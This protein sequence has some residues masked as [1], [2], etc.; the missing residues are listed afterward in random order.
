MASPPTISTEAVTTSI[1]TEAFTETLQKGLEAAAK[2]REEATPEPIYATEAVE[3]PFHHLAGLQRNHFKSHEAEKMRQ[4]ISPYEYW[5]CE[6]QFLE[7]VVNEF[8]GRPLK[9]EDWRN[10]AKGYKSLLAQIGFPAQEFEQLR[11]SISGQP[12]W[13][14]K[15]EIFKQESNR[16]EYELKMRWRQQAEKRQRRAAQ[17]RSNSSVD[18]V[19][20]RTRSKTQSRVAKRVNTSRR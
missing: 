6:V 4:R 14:H 5:E 18:H 11:L 9:M 13:R 16:R 17:P 8:R 20:S 7:D 10:L 12:Y 19:S 3:P 15:T 1:L 2:S